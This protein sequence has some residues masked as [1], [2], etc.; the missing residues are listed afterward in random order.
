VHWGSERDNIS[1]LCKVFPDGGTQCVIVLLVTPDTITAN[2]EGTQQ[3][4][5]SVG[6]ARKIQS[7]AENVEISDQ[8]GL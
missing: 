8:S 7:Q 5:P 4:Q 3:V 2:A 1:V 6:S